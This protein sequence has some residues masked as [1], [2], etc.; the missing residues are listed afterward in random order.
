MEVQNYEVKNVVF[1]NAR[2]P[3][4]HSLS[5]YARLKEL[6]KNAL[7]FAMQIAC[8]NLRIHMCSL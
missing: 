1:K 8:I 7:A 4:A 2:T 5:G 3:C 6:N